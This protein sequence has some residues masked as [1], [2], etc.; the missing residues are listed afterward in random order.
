MHLNSGYRLT[1]ASTFLSR[2][3]SLEAEQLVLGCFSIEIN[4]FG[5]FLYIEHKKYNLIIIP[6]GG[7]GSL[8]LKWLTLE[9]FSKSN[10]VA[11]KHNIILLK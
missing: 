9:W 11:T 1:L 6:Y 10:L 8:W 5:M 3:H 4:V 7:L 2:N